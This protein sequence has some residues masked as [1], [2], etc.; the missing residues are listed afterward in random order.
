MTKKTNVVRASLTGVGGVVGASIAVLVVGAL[1]VVP[2]PQLEG[3]APMFK[4]T[5]LPSMQN[6]VCPGPL[7]QVNPDKSAT[8]SYL[9]NGSPV[10]QL[11][12][13]STQ[14]TNMVLTMTD[15][16]A[17]ASLGAPSVISVP[18]VKGAS[19]QPLLAGMQLQTGK[20]ESLAGLATVSCAEPSN[21]VWLV[22]GATDVGRTTLLLLENP[23]DVYSTAKIEVFAE[24]GP[25]AMLKNDGIQVPPRTQRIISIAGYARDVYAPVI[26][27]SSSGGA[28]LATLQQS[29]MRTLVPSG[30]EWVNPSTAPST[31]QMITGVYLAGSS[32]NSEYGAVSSDLESTIRVLVPGTE[33]ADVKLKFISLAGEVT[34][35]AAPVNAQEVIQFPFVGMKDGMYTVIVSANKPIVAGVRS[36]IASGV[37][38]PVL[39]TTPSSP[40]APTSTPSATASPTPTPSATPAAPAAPAA[41]VTGGDFAWFSAGNFLTNSLLVPVPSGPNPM[42][43]FYNP[44]DW[45]VTVV[46]SARNQQDVRL[47]IA[48]GQMSTVKL[49]GGANY[50][51]KGSDGLIG[52]LTYIG[53]GQGSGTVLSPANA[54]GS[55]ISVY[56]R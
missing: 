44:F 43:S 17:P 47:K 38:A 15:N 5:P 48:P 41:K 53:G 12:S 16:K 37:Q 56:P 20:G 46:L 28:L 54:L 22:G 35:L 7:V 31:T 34:E 9:S 50:T 3:Y 40:P 10:L 33:S 36:V 6:I 25:V 24:N 4:V 49:T 27:V 14:Q 45:D 30:V 52:Q 21:D 23:T 2:L 29:V 39:S 19:E 42:L 51:V 55:A 11:D 18:P 1:L 8:V 32:A 13:T 26:H